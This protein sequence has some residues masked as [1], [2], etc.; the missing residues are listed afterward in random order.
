[1]AR[2]NLSLQEI[3]GV[4]DKSGAGGGSSFDMGQNQLPAQEAIKS[5]IYGQNQGIVD[6]QK[7]NYLAQLQKIAQADQKL[8][9]V[10]GDPTSP[11]YIEHAGRR[12]GA[13]QN[14]TN[15]EVQAADFQ[16]DQLANTEKSLEQQVTETIKA[17]DEI[18]STKKSAEVEDKRI[19]TEAKRAAKE[20]EK[21]KK[22]QEKKVKGSATTAQ[23]VKYDEAKLDANNPQIRAIWN[24]SPAGFQKWFTEKRVKGAIK[25]K[26]ITPKELGYWRTKYNSGKVSNPAKA[27]KKPTK[28][29]EL[30]KLV[31]DALKKANK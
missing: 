16:S 1:M 22:E 18:R 27:S 11:M 14:I 31:E 20:A 7:Q 4:L 17:Y 26:V 3:M 19:E 6:Q 2:S 15:N 24:N 13:I 25:D 5:S 10:Y 9:G 30:D 28:S 8:A 23:Q 29:S 12:A 21:V